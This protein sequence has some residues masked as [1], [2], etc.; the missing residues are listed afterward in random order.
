MEVLQATRSDKKLSSA[1]AKSA[2]RARNQCVSIPRLQ[3]QST[4]SE[5]PPCTD[6]MK[7]LSL[8]IPPV[9]ALAPPLKTRSAS[10][11]EPSSEDKVTK[12]AGPLRPCLRVQRSTSLKEFDEDALP[13]DMSGD[14]TIHSPSVPQLR[15][16]K[17]A[18]S[19][20]RRASTIKGLAFTE[21]DFDLGPNIGCGFFGK[22]RKV[23]HKKTGEQMVLKELI[24]CE[25]EEAKKTF[26]KEAAVLRGL[27]HPRLL[28]Y[29]GFLYNKRKDL[30]IITEFIP[31]GTLED[32]LHTSTQP[33]SFVYKLMLGIDIASAMVYSL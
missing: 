25:E 30:H 2:R 20:I 13:V 21:D 29:I 19:M 11:S 8:D 1:A 10:V 6:G 16:P 5:S 14:A 28:R 17:L 23:R 18:Q 15:S 3:V 31:G 9:A 32:L 12:R 26:L 27:S 22:V 7:S 33:L 24:T 4:I